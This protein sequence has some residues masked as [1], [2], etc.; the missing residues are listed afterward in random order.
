MK[1]KQDG[2]DIICL[3]GNTASLGTGFETCLEGGQIVEPDAGGLWDGVHLTCNDCAIVIN[4]DTLQ[5]I[6]A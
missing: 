1:I 3:C 2:G 5:I 6:R 4:Q